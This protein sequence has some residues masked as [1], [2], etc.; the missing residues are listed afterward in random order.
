M[1]NM[2]ITERCNLQCKHCG[3]EASCNSSKTGRSGY[4]YYEMTFDE[5]DNLLLEAAQLGCHDVTLAG[6]EPLLHPDLSSIISR[7]A[8]LGMNC[9]ILTNGTLLDDDMI[10]RLNKHGGVGYIRVSIDYADT[11]KMDNHRGGKNILHTITEGIKKLKAVGLVVGI[12]MTIFPDNIDE[13]KPVIKLGNKL[14]VDFIRAVPVVTRGRARYY[15]VDEKFWSNSLRNLVDA[16]CNIN[17]AVSTEFAPIPNIK[18]ICELFGNC[19]PA[20][21]LSCTVTSSGF[22]KACPLMPVDSNKIYSWKERAL[23]DIW[24]DMRKARL[25]RYKKGV[26]ILG[27]RCAKCEWAPS[28]LGGCD[29]ERSNREINLDDDQPICIPAVTEQVFGDLMNNPTIRRLLSGI[30]S[31][32]TTNLSYGINPCIRSSPLWLHPFIRK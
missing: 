22:V 25:I 16:V 21:I 10:N 31:R 26:T 4:G 8:E 28:C 19:C 14:G 7:I 18:K 12:G 24:L 30:V 5:I 3:A 15:K 17:V 13:I 32:Q 20:G 27:K 6:G 9:G 11:D 2:D 29:A 23:K 1:L